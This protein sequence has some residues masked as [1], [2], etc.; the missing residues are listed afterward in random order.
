MNSHP[1]NSESMEERLKA[2]E[3]DSA[4]VD[5]AAGLNGEGDAGRER[6]STRGGVSSNGTEE[7]MADGIVMQNTAKSPEARAL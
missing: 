3:I 1:A 2:G 7:D 5:V 4:E 6:V